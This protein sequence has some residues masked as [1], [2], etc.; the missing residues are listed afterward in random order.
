[1]FTVILL[2]K[3]KITDARALLARFVTFCGVVWLIPTFSTGF[4][5]TSANKRGALACHGQETRKCLNCSMA[6]G[7]PLHV[8]SSGRGGQLSYDSCP[9]PSGSESNSS[10]SSFTAADGGRDMAAG[11]AMGGIAEDT[12]AGDVG[13]GDVGIDAERGEPVFRSSVDEGDHGSGLASSAESAPSMDSLFETGEV[14]VDT[15]REWSSLVRVW[16]SDDVGCSSTASIERFLRLL[17][18]KKRSMRLS[19]RITVAFAA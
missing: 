18:V 12:A 2:K 6:V 19:F 16:L 7:W 14:G 3:I 9:L 8:S 10:L 13:S 1:M 15:D 4:I 5:K 11:K 17:G